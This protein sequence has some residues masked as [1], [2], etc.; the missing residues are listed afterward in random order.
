MAMKIKIAIVGIG[1]C[2]SSLIQGIY[3]YKNKKNIP[4]LLHDKIGGYKIS[5]I[6]VV[7]AFDIDRRKVGKDLSKAIFQKP[8]NTKTFFNEIH[9]LDVKVLKGPVLD[10]FPKHMNEF[11]E[12]IR[13]VEDKQKSINVVEILKK[14]K[15]HLLINY[16]PVGSEK[17][18]EYYV[19]ACLEANVSFIN[20]I[21]VFICSKEKYSNKFKERG[22]VCLGDD[23]KAQIG[24]T[25]IHRVLTNLFEKRGVKLKRTYQLNFGGNTDFLNMLKRDRLQSKKISKTEAVQS[26]L[27]S[28]LDEENIHIGPSDFIPWLKDNKICQIRM[29]GEQFGGNPVNVDLKLSV[30]DSPNSAGV[31][32]DVV[33]G[34]KFALDCGLRGYLEEISA[35]AF[36][37]PKKQFTDY[38]AFKKVEEFIKIDKSKIVG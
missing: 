12:E 20:A 38:E 37:H 7:A 1:N 14:T 26:Q 21:P 36:K 22:L 34:A 19:N 29:E 35:F 23:I 24:A 11:P 18:T 33:R 6:E 2:A 10:G 5:D 27:E 28:P 9:K 8:N 3:F 13:F 4:G 31:M 17:A 15:P 16:L 30:E 32:V 25:I